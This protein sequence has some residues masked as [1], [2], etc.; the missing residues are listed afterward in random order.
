[1]NVTTAPATALQFGIYRDGDN[2]LDEIQSPVIDQAFA[3]SAKDDAIAFNVEDFT[4]RPDFAAD[5][6]RRT[7]SYDLRGGAVSGKVGEAAEGIASKRATLAH[8][9]AHTLD[10]AETNQAQ[11]TW[12]DLVD[13]G[14]GDGGGLQT[15]HGVMRSDDMAGAIADGI[16][17]HAK[18][19]PEDAGRTLDGVVANQCLMATVGFSDALSRAGVKF[20]A[21]SPETMLAPGTPTTVAEDIAK[22]VGDTAGMAKAVVADAMHATYR[23]PMGS[24]KPAA[25][26]DVIDLDPQKIGA[27]RN[28]VRTL[29]RTIATDAG[30]SQR[31]A[32]EIRRDATGVDGMVRFD[33]GGLP[34]HADRPAE[35]LYDAFAKDAQLPDDL[36]TAA[37][38]ARDAV[39]ATVIAHAESKA[40][41]PFDDASYADAAGPT[42]H[43]A[44]DADQRDP[45]APKISETGT[46]F[47]KAVGADGVDRALGTA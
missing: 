40:F 35:A 44:V 11:Q 22:H 16:A 28:A 27:M 42:V 36:R 14:G 2:N 31:V 13:H 24:Y 43:F 21:A 38:A 33:G 20:L 7:E 23:T 47:Y 8:F 17:Q 12:V 6:G 15:P 29:D 32:S 4:A 45:W 37:G 39:G 19:H 46:A 10:E 9:V 25:A 41:G 1:M 26:F 18:D 3:V 34:W 5:E 30:A